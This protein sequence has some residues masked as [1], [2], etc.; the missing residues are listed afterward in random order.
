[1]SSLKDYR[2]NELKWFLL[3]NILL[4]LISSNVFSLSLDDNEL[5]IV[6]K[7]GTIVSV[8]FFSAIIYV[9]TFIFDSVMPSNIKVHLV[10]LFCKKPSDT[11]F[12]QI[13]RKCND[14]RFTVED[15]KKQYKEIYD[16]IDKNSK[17]KENQTA[18]WYEIYNRHRDNSIVYGSN[19]DYLLLRDLH[20]QTVTLVPIYIILALMTG[21]I[22]VSIEYLIYLFCM[23]IIL[24][25]GARVQGKRVIYNVLA[26]DLNH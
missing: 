14:D 10:F 20:S 11:I 6:E 2:N 9:Y 24:N 26:V 17:L 1:M 12:T 8:V 3:A 7:I 23:I 4:M 25:I 21:I 16:Q 13:L 18:L 22:T 5:K 19:R 15:A